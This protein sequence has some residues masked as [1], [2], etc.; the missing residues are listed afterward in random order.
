MLEAQGMLATC[1]QHEIDHLKGRVFVE[2]LSMLKQTRLK[3]KI[4]KQLR[5]LA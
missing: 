2:Y 5:Q 1:I 3:A 4:K